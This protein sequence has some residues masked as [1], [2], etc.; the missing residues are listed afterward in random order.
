MTRSGGM[1]IPYM[2][3]LINIDIYPL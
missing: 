2:A 1:H 3:W